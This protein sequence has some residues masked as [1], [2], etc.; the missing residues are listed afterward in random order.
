MGAA[1]ESG[2]VVCVDESR[3]A[4]PGPRVWSQG[5]VPR[6]LVCTFVQVKRWVC[7]STKSVDEFLCF[8]SREQRIRINFAACLFGGSQSG[9]AA[10]EGYQ[11]C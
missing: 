7:I 4:E 8:R 5:C 3:A 2:G 6:D 11:C 9:L 1:A 10:L